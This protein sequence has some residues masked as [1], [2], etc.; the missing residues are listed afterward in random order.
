MLGKG[1][2]FLQKVEETRRQDALLRTFDWR[3]LR[4]LLALTRLS[5]GWPGTKEFRS[6]Y[7]MGWEAIFDQLVGLFGAHGAFS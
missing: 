3:I 5:N 7:N 1:C 2:Q 4:M 6:F